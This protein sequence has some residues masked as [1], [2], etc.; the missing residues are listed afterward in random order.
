[1]HLRVEHFVGFLC[2]RTLKDCLL[3]F[4]LIRLS[5][6]EIIRLHPHSFLE[7][8]R[9]LAQFRA[10]RVTIGALLLVPSQVIRRELTR[11]VVHLTLLL[12]E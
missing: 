6:Q 11:K 3:E 10:V 8:F 7:Q 2:T 5:F 4:G 12:L 1:M 9:E